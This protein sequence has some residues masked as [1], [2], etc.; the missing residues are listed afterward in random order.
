MVKTEVGIII[1]RY[2]TVT[3]LDNSDGVDNYLIIVRGGRESAASL[4]T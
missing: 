2:V 1:N 4:L 3:F